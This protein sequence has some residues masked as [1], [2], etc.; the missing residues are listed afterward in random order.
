VPQVAA[1]RLR[2]ERLQ[3]TVLTAT[4]DTTAGARP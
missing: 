4:R 3:R 2:E 1:R